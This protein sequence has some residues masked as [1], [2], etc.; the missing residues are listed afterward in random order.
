MAQSGGYAGRILIVD[1]TTGSAR[2]EPLDGE[3][4]EKF[5]GGEGGNFR[6]GYDLIRP[7]MDVFSEDSPII[8]GAGPCVGI[9][10]PAS[11]R[12]FTLYKH[13]AYGVI[14]NAKGGGKLGIMLKRAGYDY[15]II[16]GKSPKRCYLGI[17]NEEVRIYDADHLWGADLYQASDALTEKHPG[18]SVCAIG[19]AGE[20]FVKTTVC[21]VDKVAT[22]G[23]GGL[24]ALMASKNLKAIVVRG[25]KPVRVADPERLDRVVSV[26]KQRI[27]SDPMRKRNLEL[28]TMAG[29]EG[30]F[31]VQG[32]SSRNWRSVL[33]ADEAERLYS[34]DVYLK[35]IKF[36]RIADPGCPVGCKDYVRVREGEFAGLETYGSSLYGRLANFAGRSNVGSF[37]RAIKA[38]DYCQRMGLCVHETT[39]LIDWATDLYRQGIITGEDTDGLKLEWDFDTTMKLLEKI[40]QNEGFGAVLGGG[41]LSA[42]EKIGR[43]CEKSAIHVKGMQ[44]LYDARVN[45]VG[46]GEFGQ[47]VNPRGAHAGRPHVYGTAKANMQSGEMFREW[48]QKRAAIPQEAIERVFAGGKVNI[49]RICKWADEYILISNNLGTGCLRGRIDKYYDAQVYTELFSAATGIETT[50]R[51]LGL[52]AER[53][54]NLL[55]VL[56]LREGFTRKDDKWP[57]RW[58]EPVITNGGKRYL[59]SYFGEPL[60]REECEKMLDDYYDERGW[61]VKSG[62]PTKSGLIALGLGDIARDVEKAGYFSKV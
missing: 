56:N 58:F 38:L 62:T 45:R 21:L 20:R 40:A 47:I 23:K 51:E 49:A 1:L 57:D 31:K 53:S 52:A 29:W 4:V 48:A 46:V 32:V 35:N 16:T 42:I 44:A 50:P 18:S 7:G 34:P 22:L 41:L 25:A 12:F 60:N 54:Y 2:K 17:H 36:R 30:W 24:P 8:F 39:A 27:Y 19:P 37:N 43:G 28:G 26:L 33:S 10:A 5:T 55:K 15:L 6:L 9:P 13:P 61:D 3:L 11:H 59:E 14:E